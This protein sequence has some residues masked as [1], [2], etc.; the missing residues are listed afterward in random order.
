MAA[1]Q[2]Y[3]FASGVRHT[4]PTRE[5]QG[6]S[7]ADRRAVRMSTGQPTETNRHDGKRPGT[8]RSW[9]N[10]E[11]TRR[12]R[13]TPA[14]APAAAK[15]YQAP[16]CGGCAC[17]NMSMFVPAVSLLLL[18][19]SL[20]ALTRRSVLLAHGWASST[21]L[22]AFTNSAHAKKC[23]AGPLVGQQHTSDCFH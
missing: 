3:W 10:W 17:A 20:T 1:S 6:R 8:H 11:R 18:L 15:Q 5:R 22:T 19:L 13:G 12:P 23:V 2:I 9:T 4:D 14:L 7:C 21:L 16:C